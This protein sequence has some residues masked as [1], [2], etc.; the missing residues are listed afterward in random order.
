MFFSRRLASTALPS[1]TM[2][3]VL[4]LRCLMG[5]L[6]QALRG[7]GPPPRAD[8]RA[9]A[10]VP[11]P[12]SGA[13]LLQEHRQG[14]RPSPRLRARQLPQ[15]PRRQAR[16][17]APQV[18]RSGRTRPPGMVLLT[19]HHPEGLCVRRRRFSALCSLSESTAADGFVKSLIEVAGLLGLIHGLLTRV[20]RAERAVAAK[21]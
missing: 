15:P 9:A 21:Q 12:V 18:G 1:H 6:L 2:D 11:R 5:C 7:P 8:P 4:M 19:R 13:G 16:D 10:P 14:G 20:S 17:P 3:L